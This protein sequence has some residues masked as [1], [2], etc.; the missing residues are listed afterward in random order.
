MRQA[1]MVAS[2]LDLRGIASEI[3]KVKTKGD[4]KRDQPVEGPIP[5][6]LFTHELEV[7]LAKKKV[8][9]AIHS[10]KDLPLELRHGLAIA[11]VLERE[12]PRDVLVVNSVTGADDLASLPAGS[13]VGTSSARRRAQLLTHRRD[14]EPAELRG[15]VPER[16]RKVERGMVHAAILSADSLIRLG[17]STRITQYLDVPDWLPAVGQGAVVIEIRV[18]DTEMR[19]ILAPLNHQLTSIATRA[20]RSFLAALG[21]GQIPVAAL[22]IP[23]SN[24]RLTLHAFVSDPAGRDPVRGSIAVDDDHPDESGRLLVREMGTRGLSSLL[25]EL[26]NADKFQA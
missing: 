15:S 26:R 13:R 1:R 12:D 21:G 25:L 17:A 4:R 3:V 20:E 14:I 2:L 7:A 19:E 11:A 8:D 16:L 10:L 24:D 22:A 18:D 6:G 9:C 23:D 5:P